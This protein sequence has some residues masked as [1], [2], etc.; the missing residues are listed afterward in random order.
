MKG[1]MAGAGAVMHA[2]AA[3]A[4]CK[5]SI[6]VTG[7]IGTAENAIGSRAMRPGD[8]LKAHN[9]K[10]ILQRI[11]RSVRRLAQMLNGWVGGQ[12]V[13]PPIAVF[14]WHNRFAQT[15]SIFTC[16]RAPSDIRLRIELEENTIIHG[17][18][19]NYTSVPPVGSTYAFTETKRFVE[20]G[21]YTAKLFLDQSIQHYYQPTI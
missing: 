21:V 7:I 5:P 1:D 16:L 13:Q 6:R 10:T 9:G 3:I 12:T 18:N 17:I 19:P 14:T 2:M 15:V 4:Q 20:K 11:D 8:I